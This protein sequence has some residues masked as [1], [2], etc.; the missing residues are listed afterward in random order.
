MS[1]FHSFKDGYNATL[2]GD[3]KRY[4]DYDLIIKTYQKVKN[5]NQTAKILNISSDSVRNVLHQNNISILTSSDVVKAA[6]QKTVGMYELQICN[7]K[8]KSAYGFYWEYL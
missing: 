7:K 1:F 3:G 5:C 4:L 8:R 2:G 6:T